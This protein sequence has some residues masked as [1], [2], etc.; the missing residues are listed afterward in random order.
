MTRLDDTEGSGSGA[1]G[2]PQL[3][4]PVQL[5]ASEHEWI[6]PSGVA[7]GSGVA[8]LLAWRMLPSPPSSRQPSRQRGPG[9][10]GRGPGGHSG[11]HVVAVTDLGVGASIT[12]SAEHLW[13]VLVVQFGEPLVLLEHYRAQPGLAELGGKLGEEHVDQVMVTAEQD[14][15]W[16]RIWP[17]APEHPDHDELTSWVTPLRDLGLPIHQIEGEPAP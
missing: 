14:V 15:R 12:N 17:T 16:R 8:R 10:R 3:I 4:H 9:R 5:V 11:G 2:W 13:A 7:A 1:A 6:Y